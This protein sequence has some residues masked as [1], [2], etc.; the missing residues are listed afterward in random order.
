LRLAGW[1]I[2]LSRDSSEEVRQHGTDDSGS[3]RDSLSV[4]TGGALFAAPLLM[5]L[6]REKY[7]RWWYDW[8]LE[9]ARFRLSP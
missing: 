8:N 2:A 4:G 5:I 3:R 1:R 9:L 6:F 7:P